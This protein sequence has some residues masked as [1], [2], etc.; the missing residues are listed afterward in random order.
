MMP[1]RF[2][3]LLLL[4]ALLIACTNGQSLTADGK[5]VT[6]GASATASDCPKCAPCA[7]RAGIDASA[8]VGV[9]APLPPENVRRGISWWILTSKGG[10]RGAW[11]NGGPIPIELAGWRC[12][13]TPPQ[14]EQ[15]RPPD[16]SGGTYEGLTV[17]CHYGEAA[18]SISATCT[19]GEGVEH[20][21]SS[22]MLGDNFHL[23][24]GCDVR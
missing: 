8:D 16:G 21:V 10:R 6:L 22:V 5:T 1:A 12:E 9:V 24:V 18:V 3:L 13:H 23:D 19:L 20:R 2:A 4:L 14:R 17:K 11:P 7:Q 15:V